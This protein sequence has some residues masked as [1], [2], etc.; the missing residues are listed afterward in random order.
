MS[1]RLEMSFL[2]ASRM[3]AFETLPEPMKDRAIAKFLRN[4]RPDLFDTDFLGD[5][6][7]WTLGSPCPVR[8]KETGSTAKPVDLRMSAFLHEAVRNITSA[9]DLTVTPDPLWTAVLRLRSCN[10]NSF[11]FSN[12]ADGLAYFLACLELRA[13]PD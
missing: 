3:S 7:L 4:R 11:D 12:L 9:M 5:F 1:Q 13:P 10:A 2:G 8:S 6:L